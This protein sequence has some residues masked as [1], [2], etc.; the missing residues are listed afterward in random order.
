MDLGI[1]VPVIDAAVTMRGISALKSERVDASKIFHPAD[2]LPVD[3]E[4]WMAMLEDG[5][6]TAF[7]I[8][9]AQ[10]LA[11]LSAAST[12]YG[13]ALDIEA[14]ARI[15]RGG[16]IIRAGLLENIRNAYDKDPGLKNLLLDKDFANILDQSQSG[17][18][19]ILKL[20]IDKA[21][22]V[23]ALGA[24]LSYL[25][26]YKSARLPLNL[27]Q[28][29]RDYFGSHTYERIDKEGTFHTDWQQ[30]VSG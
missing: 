2:A 3:E 22:P 23:S 10:G 9:Y 11:Q 26:A 14:V 30:P 13:Y 28:A 5:L 20:A 19:K 25:D 21:I 27:V 15:W 18:R 4:D 12:E 29:Q 1:P 16:C 7:I 24:S 6:Y 17:L 8:T